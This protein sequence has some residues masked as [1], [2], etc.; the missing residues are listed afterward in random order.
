[1]LKKLCKSEWIMIPFCCVLATGGGDL[2]SMGTVSGAVSPL[3]AAVAGI[4]SP[5]YSFCLL[6]GSLIA[7]CIQGAPEEMQFLLTCLISLLCIRIFFCENEKPWLS[8]VLTAV[9]CIGAGVMTDLLFRNADGKLPLYIL[10]SFLTGTAAYFFSDAVQSFRK[11]QKITLSAGKSF[12][13]AVCY[14][15]TIT[16]L[17]SLDLKFCNLGRILGIT[18]TLLASR[19]FRQ[20]AGTLCGALTACGVVLC[21]VSLGMPLLFLP[22]TAMLA[23]FLYRIPNAFY[24]PVFF[25]M[26]IFSSAVFDSS[27]GIIKVLAELVVTCTLYA[28]FCQTEFRK[29][30]AVPERVP[31]GQ[32]QVIQ[33]E[34]FLSTALQELREETSA[35]MRHLT[36]ST[37]PDPVQQVQQN[38]CQNCKYCSRCWKQNP[39][40]TAQAFRQMLHMP[41]VISE[42]LE[43]CPER[44]RIADMMAVFLQRRTVRQMQN[45]A[46]LQSRSMM[47]ESLHMLEHLAADSARRRAMLCCDAETAVL[48]NILLRCAV[49]DEGCFV[50]RLRNGRYTAEVY[51]EKEAFP[52]ATI[53]ELLSRHL[54]TE[55]KAVSFSHKNLTRYCF[56]EVPAYHLDYAMQSRNAPAYERCGD[57]AEAFTDAVGNQYLV[58]SDGMGSGSAASLASRIAVKTFRNLISCEMSLDS[59]VRLLNTLLMTETNTENFATLDI[60]FLNADTGELTFCKSGSAASLFCRK[61]EMQQIA[62]KSFPLG[63]MPDAVPFRTKLQA[64]KG[65]YLLLLSDGISE[66]EYPYIRQ[67]L[68]QTPEP[69]QILDSVFEKAAVFHGG[70]IR[71]DMTVIAARTESRVPLSVS[72]KRQNSEDSV[73]IR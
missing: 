25:L 22:V 13:Y 46:L 5:L 64:Q 47:L 27:I 4:C 58:L 72:K 53:Q 11:D 38:L 50:S 69:E 32:R 39:E 34:I 19:Q 60:L 66:A 18:V 55:I 65:D 29:F 57:H 52:L 61:N 70:T 12:T 10:E 1:M 73:T 56:Y 31:M 45:T 26:Q 14:L 59:A 37:L 33:Q 2:L 42:T 24:I 7:Y 30:I 43:A 15:L 49:S 41:S 23:G 3:A 28:I 35:V 36:V 63:M 48:K 44:R 62:A 54:D 16:A 20:S 51:S 6:L 68:A 17:C 9:T 71:D 67:I 21:S 8:G 40:Q